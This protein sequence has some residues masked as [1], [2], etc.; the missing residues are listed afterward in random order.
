[1]KLTTSTGDIPAPI[2]KAVTGY[3]WIGDMAFKWLKVNWKT[4][5]VVTVLILGA[6]WL[7]GNLPYIAGISFS[8]WVY[9]VTLLLIG[10]L[11]GGFFI[12][13]GIVIHHTRKCY[14]EPEE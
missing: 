1:M 13:T 10:F 6:L 4:V 8:V 14:R 11:A 5:T 9:Y 12:A 2:I 7:G 3:N